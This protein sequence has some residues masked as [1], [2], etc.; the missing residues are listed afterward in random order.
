M[1]APWLNNAILLRL[2]PSGKPALDNLADFHENSQDHDT[3]VPITDVS[4]LPAGSDDDPYE[5]DSDDPSDDPRSASEWL[6]SRILD[7]ATQTPYDRNR[8]LADAF[9]YLPCSPA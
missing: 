6:S 9:G 5:D 1:R 8:S 7:Q 2:H 3:D 4:Y